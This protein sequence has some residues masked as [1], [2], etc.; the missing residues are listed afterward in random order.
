MVRFKYIVCAWELLYRNRR[1]PARVSPDGR[2][3]W[4]QVAGL[5]APST[6]HYLHQWQ[7][8]HR[9]RPAFEFGLQGF[10]EMGRW[11]QW[12][13]ADQRSHLAGPAVFGKLDLGGRQ[14]IR[15]N[16]AWLLGASTAAPD[17][18]VRMQVE[19]EF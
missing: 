19:Y 10:G 15:Y 12:A 9:W 1:R 13:A 14:S 11:D 8:K 17:H 7:A 2:I 18:A 3:G 4:R 16:A 6:A 5:R